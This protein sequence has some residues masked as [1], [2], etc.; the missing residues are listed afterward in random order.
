MGEMKSEQEISQVV[1]TVADADTGF[2]AGYFESLAR[3]FL[4]A[5]PQ[6]R[7]LRIWQLLCFT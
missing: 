6:E 2:S 1:V 7:Y 5:S 4:Q 3:S